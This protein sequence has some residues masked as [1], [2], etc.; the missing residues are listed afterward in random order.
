MDSVVTTEA[1]LA[2]VRWVN[3]I[4]DLRWPYFTACSARVRPS[5]K[6][7]IAP[8]ANLGEREVAQVRVV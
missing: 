8:A 4:A 3:L 5:P 2:I 1:A 6:A 7:T